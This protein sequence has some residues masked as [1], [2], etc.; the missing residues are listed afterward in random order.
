MLRYAMPY[1][2]SVRNITIGAALLPSVPPVLESII[3][4]IISR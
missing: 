2:Q 4:I 1:M 3:S